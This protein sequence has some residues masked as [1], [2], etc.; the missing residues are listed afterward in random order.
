MK[1]HFH[2]LLTIALFLS[3]CTPE[4]FRDEL[5]EQP[6]EQFDLGA[7]TLS[8]TALAFTP[9]FQKSELVFVDSIGQEYQFSMTAPAYVPAYQFVSRYPHP[10]EAD[11]EVEYRYSGEHYIF[12]FQSMQ[13]GA[14]LTVALRPGLC[15]N[16]N[17]RA[18]GRV[19][20]H[21]RIDARGFNQY[22]LLAKDPVVEISI[23]ADDLCTEGRKLGT[24]SYLDRSFSDVYYS[25]RIFRGHAMGIYYN[26]E[27]GVV[28]IETPY[29]FA[30][31][32]RI[33]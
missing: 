32:D 19:L 29:L 6:A 10:H 33:N 23:L 13:L 27:K 21:L 7:Y 18:D 2:L 15:T 16:P 30:V 17:L 9:Y 22:D 31:L 28:A 25:E 20:D 1:T 8:E 4:T 12:D 3:T 5:D 14:K 26:N 24:F 11:Q